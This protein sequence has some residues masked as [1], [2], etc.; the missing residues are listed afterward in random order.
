M[1][2]AASSTSA[3]SSTGDLPRLRI[4]QLIDQEYFGSERSHHARPFG[5]VAFRHDRDEWITLDGAN[6]GESR[7]CVAAGQF[8][9]GLT[10]LEFSLGFCLLDH[11][12]RYAV[13]LRK[14]GVEI[15]QFGKDA[16]LKPTREPGKFDKWSVPDR[17]Q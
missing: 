1:R 13:F 8:H 3:R 15:F 4:W 7:P 14:A 12:Q 6:N 9:N 10:G 2:W 11:L 16:P 17:A 5:R